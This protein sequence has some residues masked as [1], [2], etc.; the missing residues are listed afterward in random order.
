MIKRI[1]ALFASIILLLGLCS[2]SCGP[3]P[4]PGPQHSPETMETAAPPTAPSTASAPDATA[5]P[6]KTA[7]E[8]FIEFDRRI[9]EE[10]VTAD[11]MTFHQF[12]RDAES[13]G[14]DE[15]A[16]EA[17]WG[18]Y[19][20]ESYQEGIDWYRDSLSELETIDRSKL[21]AQNA[22][23]Y[24]NLKITFTMGV[25]GAD[26]YYFDEPLTPS[27]G[28]HTSLPLS[29]SLFEIADAD[30]IEIYLSLL[31]DL[32]RY[33]GQIEQFE[34]EK[35]QNNIFMT[36]NA[37]DQ[38]IASCRKYVGEGENSFLITSFSDKLNDPQLGISDAEKSEYIERGRAAVKDRLLPA[39]D[40]LA[41][42]LDSLRDS[43][44][45]N[46][47]LSSHG[48]RYTEYFK[49]MVKKNAACTDSYAAMH[50]LLSDSCD[51]TYALMYNTILSYPDALDNYGAAMTTGSI[52]S[53]MSFI[54]GVT[55]QLYPSIAEQTVEYQQVPEALSDSF[56]PAA[57]MMPAFD[58]P[59]RN[60]ILLNFGDNTSDQLFTLAH[61]GFPGH[62]YQTQY[63]RN[64]EGLSLT[65]QLLA[66]IG[67]SEGWAVFSETMVASQCSE[68]G[69]GLCTLTQY[70]SLW[71]GTLIPAYVSLQVNNAGWTRDDVQELL[72]NF[73][74][75]GDEFND[76]I[77]T[78]Y[79]YA[80]DMPY[81]FMPY[82]F[83][84]SYTYDLYTKAS[85]A[86][87]FEPKEYF[88]RYLDCGPCYYNQMYTL[89]ELDS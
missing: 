58:D 88:G 71:S 31:E 46:A 86:K 49:Y 84:Y 23:A 16:V 14:I 68:L 52:Q 1:A 55:E 42:T 63:F 44:R 40:K 25:E 57:Y 77:D 37:L 38:V 73:N 6:M 59:A 60:I 3:A 5:A 30:D 51:E 35:A 22:I 54:K 47:G 76:Y 61:E 4:A 65:Q 9:F 21:S 12:V 48:E 7:D 20:Y 29:L 82:A 36:E 33:L 69:I 67:Y 10:I 41:N 72:A 28:D 80:V 32:P 75:G 83:G 85:S 19:T 13:F 78:L 34:V 18:D 64:K 87:G 50:S 53:D 79:E 62:L 24:D 11:E 17:G 26:Y 66:P 56:S 74:M 15:T 27:N 43:C 70:D 39:Y 2:C 45:E 89:L 81:T 8:L